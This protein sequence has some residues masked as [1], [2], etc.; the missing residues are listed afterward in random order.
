VIDVTDPTLVTA[1]RVD[2]GFSNVFTDVFKVPKEVSKASPLV[3][4]ILAVTVPDTAGIDV[5]TAEV[6]SVLEA[7]VHVRPVV[8]TPDW[9]APKTVL[10]IAPIALVPAGSEP[11]IPKLELEIEPPDIFTSKLGLDI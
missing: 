3:V 11:E 8:H 10:V 7:R 5:I 1:A 4:P 6:E 9:V 2:A